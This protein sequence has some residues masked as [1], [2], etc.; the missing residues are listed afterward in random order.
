MAGVLQLM[1][2]YST[3]DKPTI[4]YFFIDDFTSLVQVHFFSSVGK[5]IFS[6]ISF[7]S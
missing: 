5:N 1:I 4:S 2:I 6:L 7:S 3:S